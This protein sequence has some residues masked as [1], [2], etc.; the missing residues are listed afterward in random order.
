MINILAVTMEAD[1]LDA[2]AGFRTASAW[3]DEQ[4]TDA[5]AGRSE[6]EKAAMLER[7]DCRRGKVKRG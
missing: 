5:F 2:F 1:V 3:C 4:S 7:A 6:G